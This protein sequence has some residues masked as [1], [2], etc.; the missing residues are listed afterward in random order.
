MNRYKVEIDK[1]DKRKEVRGRKQ[2][3][4]GKQGSKKK[5]LKGKDTIKKEVE[6]KKMKRKYRKE[7]DYFLHRLNFCITQAN[8]IFTNIELFLMT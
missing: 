2:K 6:A 7:G 3:M 4:E 8:N 1:M 5:E